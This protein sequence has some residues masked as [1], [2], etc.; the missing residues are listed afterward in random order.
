[1]I[2]AQLRI[3]FQLGRNDAYV[4]EFLKVKSRFHTLDTFT[5][6]CI[7]ESKPATNSLTVLVHSVLT[8]G[9]ISDE[10]FNI[11]DRCFIITS[12][13]YYYYSNHKT[14]FKKHLIKNNL[15]R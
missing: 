11:F 13:F 5:S 6:Y 7:D 10:M 4:S 14:A 12:F 8:D 9:A 3:G 1:M 15:K 2:S